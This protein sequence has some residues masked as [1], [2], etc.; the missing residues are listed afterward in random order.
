MTTNIDPINRADTIIDYDPTLAERLT[1]AAKQAE[2]PAEL[3]LREAAFNEGPAGVANA[4]KKLWTNVGAYLSGA[5]RYLFSAGRS[6]AD[7]KTG[8][9]ISGRDLIALLATIGID[10]GLLALAAL[11]PPPAAAGRRDGLAGRAFI[12]GRLPQRKFRRA[13][14]LFCSLRQSLGE[15]RIVAGKPNLARCDRHA[16]GQR[17]HLR[18]G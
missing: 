15:V 3:T 10:L 6:T 18:S 11:N 1:Q 13:L 7:T 2:R 16:A 17:P 5:V 9:P 8:E 14:G 4:V 12:K